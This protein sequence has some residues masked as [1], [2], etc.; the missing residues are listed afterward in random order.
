MR[1]LL[2]GTTGYIGKRLL[3]VLLQE[4]HEIICCVR[5]KTRIADHIKHNPQITIIEI[6]FLKSNKITAVASDID[7]AYYFIHSMTSS[8]NTFDKLEATAA[9]NFRTCVEHLKAKQV[10]YLGGI[11]NDSSLSKHLESRKTVGSI[12]K[13]GNYNTTIL[14]AGIIIGSG[15]ASFEIMRDLVEK[16]PIMITPKWVETKSQ[17][18]AIRDVI[19]Y[20]SKIKDY[21]ACQ[22]QT[23]D[24]TG[25]DILTYKQMMLQFAKVR[26]LKRRIFTVPVMTPR[27]SSYWL[28]FVTSTSYNL[29]VN[30]VDSIK[31][32]V[33]GSPNNLNQILGHS[34]I[35]FSK[36]VELA[37]DKIEQNLVVSSWK[38]SITNSSLQPFISQY[39]ESPS[40]GCFK[41]IQMTPIKTSPEC[42]RERIWKIGGDNGWYYANK[43]WKIRGFMD[44]VFGGVGLR[45][46]RTHPKQINTGDVID[47]WRVVYANEKSNR[48]VLYAEMTLPGEAWLEFSIVNIFS[49]EYLIQ[50]ATFRP[51][52]VWGRLYWF[53][54][55]PFHY[56]IFRGMSRRIA[57][58]S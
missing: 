47:F 22:N 45:R 24:I 1:I 17:P 5:D 43:L 21:P 31:V 58:K 50:E 18:I 3:P 10:I 37:Y 14:R 29:A 54:L 30:L 16:L 41:D 39:I 8:T 49:K 53:L 11:I 12:L 56:F 7:V 40:F 9:H 13:A 19:F 42:V 4:G 32:E 55:I 33:I 25:P 15:S 20:L 57:Q 36:A 44:K 34:P 35:P 48:L 26:N 2:T 27:L 52:G 23:Y 6:D 38:D 46:G 51:R 28:Y